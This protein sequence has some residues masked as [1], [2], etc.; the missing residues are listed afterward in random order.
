MDGPKNPAMRRSSAAGR[1]VNAAVGSAVLPLSASL[2]PLIRLDDSIKAL[3]AAAPVIKRIDVSIFESDPSYEGKPSTILELGAQ[4]EALQPKVVKPDLLTALPRKVLVL[5]ASFVAQDDA[6]ASVKLSTVCRAFY[7]A[8]VAVLRTLV[9][10]PAVVSIDAL[11]RH[12]ALAS[13]AAFLSAPFRGQHLQSLTFVAPNSVY[14]LPHTTKGPVINAADLTRVLKQLP[15]LTYLDVRGV[16]LRA[17]TPWS[18]PFLADMHRHCPKLKVLRMG[19]GQLSSWE[20][21][22]WQQLTS[23]S[24]F[25]VGSRREDASWALP[26]VQSTTPVVAAPSAPSSPIKGEVV[27]APAS[28]AIAL[29]DDFFVMLRTLPSLRVVKVW[30]PLTAQSATALLLPT[31]AIP[32]VSHLTVNLEGNCHIKPLEEPAPAKE[33]P[34]DAPKGGAAKG[35]KTA[36]KQQEEAPASAKVMFPAL[37]SVTICDVKER[38]ELTAELMVKFATTAP[39]VEHWNITNTHRNAPGKALPPQPV[40]GRRLG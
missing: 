23:L 13:L 29:P 27:T 10:C 25:V 30:A 8:S 3:A 7:Q 26:V 9:L 19:V 32:N 5:I 36:A 38:P 24:D 1:A 40:K 22:W 39:H 20:P 35:A 12:G 15:R 4:L 18:D 31:V 2:S 16:V 28:P 37:Q 11:S 14:A 34:K 6:R 33:D 17:W 21:G